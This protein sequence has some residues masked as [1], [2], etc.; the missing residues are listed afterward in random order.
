[1]YEN[2]ITHEIEALSIALENL[3][4]AND[5]LMAYFADNSNFAYCTA[6]DYIANARREIKS[7]ICEL[8]GLI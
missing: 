5:T 2:N 3:S 7:R 6:M 8:K 1:M 4:S